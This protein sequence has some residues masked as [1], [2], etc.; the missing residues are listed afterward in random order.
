MG[1]RSPR[2]LDRYAQNRLTV[3]EAAHFNANY[4]FKYSLSGRRILTFSV[5]I[6]TQ[7]RDR[8]SA[9]HGIHGFPLTPEVSDTGV[10]NGASSGN[11]G[12]EERQ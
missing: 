4:A 5:T 3:I 6:F 7:R 11:R 9:V 8:C 10:E 12:D 2:T 1:L